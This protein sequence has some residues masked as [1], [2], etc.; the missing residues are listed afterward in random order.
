MLNDSAQNISTI[1]QAVQSIWK[2][3]GLSTPRAGVVPLADLVASYP[4]WV[5]EL[6]HL[7]FGRVAR[8]LE[9]R[10]G[11]SPEFGI[12]GSGVLAGFL[13][14]HVFQ[15]RLV[16]C[17][18]VEKGD[19][20]ARRRFSIAHEL[21][22]YKLH[23]LPQLEQL[24]Q[25]AK[26]EGLVIADA[27][28]YA[29]TESATGS[30]LQSA[31]RIIPSPAEEVLPQLVLIIDDAKEAEANQFAA[32]LLMPEDAILKCLAALHLPPGQSRGYLAA[33]LSSEFL[34]S[35]EAMSI[36]LAALGI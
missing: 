32:E 35:R 20:V 10:T 21:G 16:G 25:A 1:S 31:G 5:A 2:D 19:P 33:R 18:L 15:G 23:F 6:G 7:T 30:L 17:I 4:I 34:V 22:H 27:M 14:A 8:Y 24:S 28:S 12:G 9:E 26:G 13:Y 36:R 29:E 3:A 11:Q